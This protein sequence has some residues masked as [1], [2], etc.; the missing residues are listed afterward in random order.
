MK[1]AVFHG[2]GKPL[3]IETVPDPAPGPG[4]LILRVTAC[5]ICGSDL[6]FADLHDATGGVKPLPDGTVMGH[7]FAGEVVA[8]GGAVQEGW[9]IG[10]RVTA[11]PA[12]GCGRCLACLSGKGMRCTS[13]QAIG[14]G[15]LAGG[16]AEYVRVGA[17][18]SFR[19][20]DA[21]DDHAG[22]MVEPLAVGLHAVN[23]A[24]IQPGESVLVIGAGPIGLAVAAWCRF[25]GARHVLV[26]DLVK[27]RLDRAADFGATGCIEAD[28]EEVVPRSIQLAG[29]RPGIVFDCVG[30]PGSQQLAMHYAPVDGRVVVVGVCMQADRLLPI[31]GIGKELQVNYVLAYRLQDFAFAVQMLA[32]GRIDPRPML[33]G[34]VAFDAFPQTFESLKTSKRD[35]KVLLQP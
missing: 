14:L 2:A 31:V 34:T 8:A 15:V 11:M 25:F 10:T 13:G 23:A 22:A 33:S 21:V 19:L 28:H 24:R 6:H 7:E 27:S 4:D 3:A 17:F 20:P 1:A 29:E 9:A 26:S 18:E 32:A 5:G 30:V 12:I 35:C 16:Y